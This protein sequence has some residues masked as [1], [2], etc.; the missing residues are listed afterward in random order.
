MDTEEMSLLAF[1]GHAN[2]EG[3][4]EEH[5]MLV[6]IAF[7]KSIQNCNT[8]LMSNESPFEMGDHKRHCLGIISRLW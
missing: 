4:E 8:L 5:H 2:D 3:L 6:D 7:G 1:H